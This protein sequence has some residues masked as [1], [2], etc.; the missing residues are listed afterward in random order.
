MT[1][2]NLIIATCLIIFGLFVT[3][4]DFQHRYW[5]Q[6]ALI[7]AGYLLGNLVTVADYAGGDR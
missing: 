4:F 3:G 5:E 6:G 7:I 2:R 1:E